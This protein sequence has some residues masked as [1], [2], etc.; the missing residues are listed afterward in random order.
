MFPTI[1]GL[2]GPFSC[3]NNARL[4]KIYQ[5][6]INLSVFKKDL[7]FLGVLWELPNFVSIKLGSTH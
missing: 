6:I 7:E 4:L 1:K 3:L 5:I 2:K